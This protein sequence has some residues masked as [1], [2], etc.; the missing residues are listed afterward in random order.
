MPPRDESPPT[1]EQDDD[2]HPELE[3]DSDSDSSDS[4]SSD[5][6]EEKKK[7]NRK[8]AAKRKKAKKQKKSDTKTFE[9]WIVGLLGGEKKEHRLTRYFK[10]KFFEIARSKVEECTGIDVGFVRSLVP[11]YQLGE[12][13]VPKAIELMKY[14]A[15]SSITI[16]D[17]AWEVGESV[18]KWLSEQEIVKHHKASGPRFRFHG[19]HDSVADDN[20]GIASAITWKFFWF[21]DTLCAVEMTGSFLS[22]YQGWGDSD[23]DYEYD[24]RQ[25]NG[26]NNSNSHTKLVLRCFGFQ[27]RPLRKLIGLCSTTKDNRL[28]IFTVSGPSENKQN[29]MT[30]R[31]K[32]A[33]ETID[34]EPEV[35]KS[36]SEDIEDFYDP[37]TKSWYADSGL[38]N[39]YRRGYLLTGP[40]GTG[41]TSLVKAIASHAEKPLYVFTLAGMDDNDLKNHFESL[42]D[43]GCVVVLEDVDSAGVSRD[44]FAE[45]LPDPLPEFLEM[46]E[47]LLEDEAPEPSKKG[48]KKRKEVEEDFESDPAEDME[49]DHQN[50]KDGKSK[51]FY[52]PP[53][54]Q[55]PPPPPKK[56][57]LS[58]LLNVMD[59]VTSKDGVLMIMTTNAP[60]SLDKALIRPG[61]VD[62]NIYMGFSN[63]ITAGC[64]FRRIYGTDPRCRYTK[65]Q[66]ERYSEMFSSQVPSDTFSTA[67]IINYLVQRRGQ[68]KKAVEEFRLFL[69]DRRIGRDQF[70]YDI[71]DLHPE[72]G[73]DDEPLPTTFDWGSDNEPEEQEQEVP[74]TLSGNESWNTLYSGY[75]P[76]QSSEI[77]E[78]PIPAPL[79]DPSRFSSLLTPLHWYQNRI[80][81]LQDSV[82]DLE[83]EEEESENEGLRNQGS[84]SGAAKT[85]SDEEGFHTALAS[86]Q[87]S[88]AAEYLPVPEVSPQVTEE[89]SDW[90]EGLHKMASPEPLEI[91]GS[92]VT[93]Q[94]LRPVPPRPIDEDVPLVLDHREEE[95]EELNSRE[96]E[97]FDPIMTDFFHME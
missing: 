59:G 92:R 35:M 30:T 42:P 94:R 8:K 85:L 80:T 48:K 66:I 91:F 22:S 51:Q 53:R 60:K 63:K 13:W 56:V 49:E 4:E 79:S 84:A 93:F 32:R 40:P 55:P 16:D 47:D 57:T 86:P 62:R 52:Q 27:N 81:Q 5:D 26:R 3:S 29:H 18:Q 68:P 87:Q 28:R 69:D 24:H 50:K 44:G 71:N 72:P 76:P 25:Y 10:D 7:K 33:L 2:T 41:K 58:G 64:S 95:L 70:Q 11:V 65:A 77:D 34:L 1:W 73:H 19:Q 75:S 31:P 90:D 78:E 61:R 46:G 54:P 15:T 37:R 82:E 20:G 74:D 97:Y 12:I 88:A 6:E 23:E 43:D 83:D 9:S 38:T 14:H 96:T 45:C 89:E 17:R 39:S 67:E 21:D 36:L